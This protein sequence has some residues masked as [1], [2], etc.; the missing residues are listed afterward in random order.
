MENLIGKL[1]SGNNRSKLM[2]TV[3]FTNI[4]NR[5]N[6]IELYTNPNGYRYS[7]RLCNQKATTQLA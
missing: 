2:E 1:F 4:N 6:Y 3:T 5:P 7:C